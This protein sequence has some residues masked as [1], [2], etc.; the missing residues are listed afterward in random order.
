[1]TRQRN[2]SSAAAFIFSARQDRLRSPPSNRYALA[3]LAPLLNHASGRLN[4]LLEIA[5]RP[6]P[7]QGC[8]RHDRLHAFAGRLACLVIVPNLRNE[9]C[10]MLDTLSFHNKRRSLL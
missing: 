5:K 3:Y 10:G 1:M 6:S 9:H 2:R 4:A 7:R 8:I